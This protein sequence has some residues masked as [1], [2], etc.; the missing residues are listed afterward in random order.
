MGRHPALD[1]ISQI[2]AVLSPAHRA[3]LDQAVRDLSVDHLPDD[4]VE[5][6]ERAARDAETAN[7][8]AGESALLWQR[9]QVYATLAAAPRV[10]L[11]EHVL[12]ELG[13]GKVARL[14]A[15]QDTTGKDAPQ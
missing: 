5:R 4:P 1:T 6:A 12:G 10:H 2:A 15:M 9:A 13:E 8:S 14:P 11:T 3:A 7:R